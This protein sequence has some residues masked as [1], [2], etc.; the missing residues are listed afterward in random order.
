[1]RLPKRA[2]ERSVFPSLAALTALASGCHD[3]QC[4]ASREDE[5]RAHADRAR[6]AASPVD[7]LREIAI[8]LGVRAH[9]PRAELPPDRGITGGATPPVNVVPPPP[10]PPPLDPTPPERMHRPGERMPVRVTPPPTP[11]ETHH[12]RHGGRP[13]HVQPSPEGDLGE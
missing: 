13:A 12:V 9:P 11:V 10:P 8:A 1:M 7:S 6:L 5:L 2:F 4:G 3:P